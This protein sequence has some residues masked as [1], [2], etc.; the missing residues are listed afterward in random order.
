MTTRTSSRSGTAPPPSAGIRVLAEPATAGEPSLAAKGE[1][2][3]KS[4]IVKEIERDMISLSDAGDASFLQRFFKTGPGEYGAGDH[5]RGIR[6]PALRSLVRNHTQVTHEAAVELLSSRYHEDR[7]L[8]LM[9]LVRLYQKGDEP[10]RKAIYA[11][12]LENTA[13]VN[14]W[15][16]VDSS[17]PFIAGAY[18][19][20]RDRAPLHRLAKSKS[21]WERRISIIASF[22]FIKA[23]DFGDS[24]SIAGKLLTDKEDLIHK[25]VGWMLRE[26]GS[27]DGA[28]EREFLLAHYATMPRTML[29]YAIEKFPEAERQT[30][31]K[32]TARAVD[33][34]ASPEEFLPTH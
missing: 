14:N 19:M 5:F 13:Q 15:D 27:R 28:V 2:M 4:E 32:G 12:Y 25:A 34:T 26:I 22:A 6:V 30:Y 18:L 31:L 20:D 21:L 9:M 11:S 33:V 8:A 24:L 23:S 1:G 29:R 17:A 7:L 16:L 10:L 3:T